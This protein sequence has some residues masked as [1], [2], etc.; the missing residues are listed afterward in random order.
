MTEISSLKILVLE[1]LD[2]EGLIY[3]L[4]NYALPIEVE[5]CFTSSL[6]KKSIPQVIDL[7]LEETNLYVKEL[8]YSTSKKSVSQNFSPYLK[9]SFSSSIVLPAPVLPKPHLENRFDS[10][11]VESLLKIEQERSEELL[12]LVVQR[13]GLVCFEKD[14]KNIWRRY[15]QVVDLVIRTLWRE[16]LNSPRASE[17]GIVFQYLDSGIKNIISYL[18]EIEE[19]STLEK[20]N[21]EIHFG[22]N[23]NIRFSSL[24]FSEENQKRIWISALKSRVRIKFEEERYSLIADETCL[25]SRGASIDPKE[26]GREYILY[27]KFSRDIEFIRSLV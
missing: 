7:Y 23:F 18:V 19:T 12:T 24:D 13:R 22:T 5:R 25:I 15:P 26:I 6:E 4:R 10:A 3:L 8:I 14:Y 1:C 16:I 2:L 17:F 9:F 11:I 21:R 27:P 20:L